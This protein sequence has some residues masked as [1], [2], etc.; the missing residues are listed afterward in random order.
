MKKTVWLVDDD[1]E[2]RS[3]MQLMFLAL[4]Y[5]LRQ[6]SDGREVTRALLSGAAP[7]LLFLDLNMPEV[8]GLDILQFIRSRKEWKKLPILIVS[9]DSE[10]ARVEQT[11]RMGADGYVF[12]P[13]SLEEL[14]MAIS[15][16][17]E[18]RRLIYEGKTGPL[19]EIP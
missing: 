18:K 6:F 12:K 9:S 13:V 5:Q 8:A 17:S 2:M 16:A 19:V 4:G 10:D 7:D 14:E 11:M 1:A 3:A 15:T